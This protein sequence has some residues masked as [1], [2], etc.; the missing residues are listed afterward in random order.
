VAA[1]VG[2][3]VMLGRADRADSPDTEA[4]AVSAGPAVT[5]V[6][7]TKPA[8][9]PTTSGTAPK[10]TAPASSTGLADGTYTGPAARTRWGNVQVKVTIQSGKIVSVDETQAPDSDRKSVAINTRAAPVLESEAVAAQ[11]ANIRA[12][13]GATY[14]SQTYKTSLQ[15]A[16]DQAAQ[17]G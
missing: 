4:L 7:S 8:T 13:S 11:S 9:T 12:V 3:A 10:T 16:L 15:G 2:V 5:T 14:T 1:T 6:S 17:A